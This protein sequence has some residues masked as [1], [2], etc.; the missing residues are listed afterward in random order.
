[1]RS[2]RL[3]TADATN[4][5]GETLVVTGKVAG[6]SVRPAV[7]ILSIDKAFPNAPFTAVV[8]SRATNK[9]PGLTNLQGKD[10]EVS[11]PIK[12]YRGKPEIIMSNATQLTIV[13]GTNLTGAKQK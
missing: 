9:F 7:V 8:F 6:V 4:H 12:A 1:M 11:G 5:Y 2:K 13:G 10:V 3:E